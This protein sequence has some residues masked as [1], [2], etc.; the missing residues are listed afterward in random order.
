MG[1]AGRRA[2]PVRAS[3][4]NPSNGDRVLLADNLRKCPHLPAQW[5]CSGNGVPEWSLGTRRGTARTREENL[6]VHLPSFAFIHLHFAG[7][8]F[9]GISRVTRS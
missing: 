1:K 2:S 9:G 5:S 6:Q 3:R 7:M 8:G 4:L